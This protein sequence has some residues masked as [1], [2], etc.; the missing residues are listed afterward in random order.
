M[1]D[2]PSTEADAARAFI[3][4]TLR[5]VLTDA[6]EAFAARNSTAVKVRS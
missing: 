3:E 1:T 5:R 2:A 6:S 4:Q